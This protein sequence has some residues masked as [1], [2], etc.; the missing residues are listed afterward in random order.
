MLREPPQEVLCASQ[1]RP[2]TIVEAL[3]PYV[4]DQPGIMQWQQ[5]LVLVLVRVLSWECRQT[6]PA[7][8]LDSDADHNSN[9]AVLVGSHRKRG[10]RFCQ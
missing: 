7:Q 10:A 1:P 5:K 4:I 6:G 9:F 8:K 2:S 3:M